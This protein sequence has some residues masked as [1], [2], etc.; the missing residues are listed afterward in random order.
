MIQVQTLDV[1]S[2]AGRKVK[3]VPDFPKSVLI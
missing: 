1:G 2:E 3:D